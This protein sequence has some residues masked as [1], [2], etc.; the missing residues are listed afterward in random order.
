MEILLEE[1]YKTDLV[2]EK[3]HQRKVSIDGGSYQINGITKSGKTKLI[4]NYLLSRKKSSYLYVDCSDIRID[5]EAFNAALPSFCNKNKIDV[6][7]L[8]NYTPAFIFPNVTQLLVASELHHE[9]PYLQTI[10]LYPLDYE[11]FLAYEHKYDSSALNHFVQ[12]G[13][14]AVMHRVNADE[15]T[16]FLQKMLRASLDD[17][18][19]AIIKL[20]AKFISQKLSA[21]MIYER[22]K[23]TR[24]ISK[25]KLYKSFEA[26]RKKNYIHLL[27][28]Y[29]H[30][31]ATKKVYL[32][33]TSIKSALSIEKNFGR[34]FENMVYLEL[35][36]SNTESYYE[37]GIDFYLPRSD[38]ILLCK[39]FADERRLFKKLESIEAF[40]FS[41]GI[42][43]ITVITMNKEG[44]ISHPFA[45]VAIIPFDIWALGD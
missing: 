15:R 18:E 2:L 34:L 39:P 26:L 40:I 10:M 21:F 1:Y 28:K 44:T 27:E 6:L 17:V 42:R 24:K 5:I 29:G 45:K 9:L 43:K 4:K 19:F 30:T 14:F 3:F 7:A 36:K 37:D 20:C 11:E 23:L 16:L 31:R 22:L 41:Y 35:L 8:D 33:D 12:L 25:D 38:E 13:G 32:C